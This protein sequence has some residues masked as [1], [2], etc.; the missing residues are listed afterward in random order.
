MTNS[1]EVVFSFDTTGSMYPCLTQVRR[2]VKSTVTRLIEEIPE[3]RIGIIAHGDYCD[4]NSTYVTKTLDLSRDIDKICQFIETVEPTGGGDA[5]ECYELVLHEAQSL[6]WTSSATKSFVLIGDDLPHAPKQNPQH[7][8]WR[9]ELEKLSNQDITV[10]GVQALNRPH[11]TP[12][13]Q[14][15]ANQSGG[16]HISLDQFSYITD[17]FLAVCYQQD[18]TDKLQSYEQEIL[19]S[20]RMSRGL[21]KIFNTLL[22]RESSTHY[23][24]ADLRT[25]SPG[26][27]QVLDVDKDSPIK[28]FVQENGLTFK[29]GRGFYEFTKTETIQSQKEIVLMDRNTG[30]LFEG[31]AAREM[32]GL[33]EGTTARIKPSNLEKYVVF[34]QSTSYNRK[35]LGGT[36]FLYEVEDWTR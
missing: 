23:E 6:N 27:F 5:P 18:S 32:L 8:N 25:V 16:F 7:L 30:D 28:V 34:V 14:E 1:I 2:K 36:R 3:I 21:N 20:G 26:R 35:L 15:L 29:T 12:F 4:R 11:A 22:N 10:Y 31:E 19:D 9:E 17:L 33:P 24:A 13:Y